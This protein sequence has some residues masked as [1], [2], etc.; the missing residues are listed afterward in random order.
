MSLL[1]NEPAMMPNRPFASAYGAAAGSGGGFGV[2]SGDLAKTRGSD[3]ADVSAVACGAAGFD[4]GRAFSPR[5]ALA[6]AC[7]SGSGA[8]TSRGSSESGGAA[9]A[10][11][12]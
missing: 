5:F 3:V 1:W 10:G 6:G 11:V 12:A 9:G 8:G 7:G 2:V 4:F